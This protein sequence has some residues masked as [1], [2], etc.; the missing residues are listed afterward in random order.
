MMHIEENMDIRVDI[1][2]AQANLPALVLYA[3]TGVEIVLTKNGIP[4]ASISPI[5]MREADR[6]GVSRSEVARP[7]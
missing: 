5:P 6:P 7:G 4:L 1:L 3:S 2:E